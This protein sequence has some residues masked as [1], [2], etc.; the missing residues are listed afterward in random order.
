M[1]MNHEEM[2]YLANMVYRSAPTELGRELGKELWYHQN[3]GQLLNRS[4]AASLTQAA[5]EH[6]DVFRYATQSHR[7]DEI[8]ITDTPGHT[9]YSGAYKL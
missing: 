6:G 3:T 8:W 4:W 7:L 1:S 2:R 5:R 9:P